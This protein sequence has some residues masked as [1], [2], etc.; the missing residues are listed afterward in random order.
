MI[1][2]KNVSKIINVGK[3]QKKI[4][5][6]ISFSIYRGEIVGYVGLNG[7]GKSTTIK[8]LCGIYEP[9]SGIVKVDNIIPH[10]N[11]I[12][13]GFNIG[14]VFG[15]RTQL[16]WDL[17]L[18]DSF[19]ILRIIYKIPKEDFDKRL[20]F[21]NK[22]F[23]MQKH[24]KSTVRTLSLGERMKADLIASMLHNPKVLFLDEPT[25]GL[26][27]ISKKK[28]IEA[29][30]QINFKYKTTIL[31]TTHD[32]KDV[33]ALC[34]RVIVLKNGRIIFDGSMKY[35]NQKYRQCKFLEIISTLEFLKKLNVHFLSNKYVIR[36]NKIILKYDKD[37]EIIK[38][39][40]NYL[41]NNSNNY[42]FTIKEISLADIVEKI[43]EDYK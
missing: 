27:T 12:K 20:L 16:W 2:V 26:D 8:M 4:V 25:I 14:V 31:L 7:S 36:D 23:D 3:K 42:D 22:L 32:F 37:D 38:K 30:K 13:N 10:K 1:S 15:Q 43:N 35:I 5:D 9:T 24:L 40:I 6:D 39:T 19:K 21:L 17:P 33:E 28:T 11:R 18:E 34:D 41:V 29:I